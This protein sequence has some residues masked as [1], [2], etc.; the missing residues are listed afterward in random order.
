MSR[1]EWGARGA[2][3]RWLL[4]MVGAATAT[5]AGGC[6][7]NDGGWY[8]QGNAEGPALTLDDAA[9]VLTYRI[10]VD[11]D[12]ATF[13]SDAF[14]GALSIDVTFTE[15]D[16]G[17]GNASTAVTASL[18]PDAGGAAIDAETAALVM[19]DGASASVTLADY[20][21]FAACTQGV[22]G[23]LGC[24]RLE[25]R[26]HRER[27]SGLAGGHHRRHDHARALIRGAA[28]GGGVRSAARRASRARGRGR[29]PARSRARALSRPR[30]PRGLRRCVGTSSKPRA[31]R[32]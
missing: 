17:A 31:P 27:W 21:V 32:R 15:T 16:F 10:A 20:D 25:S 28:R 23:H 14:E 1:V 8:A 5:L 18:L 22:A 26:A 19:G 29:A 2:R 9:P 13:P 24:D 11:A 7:V 4:G 12:A 6:P 3:G 30:A